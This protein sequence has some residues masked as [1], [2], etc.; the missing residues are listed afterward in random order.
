MPRERVL[1]LIGDF[2]MCS[3]ELIDIFCYQFQPGFQCINTAVCTKFHYCMDTV[4]ML[5]YCSNSIVLETA[6]LGVVVK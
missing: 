4:F 5:L 3:S 1:F 2:N 6:F